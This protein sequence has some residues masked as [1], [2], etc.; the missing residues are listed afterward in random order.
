MVTK[1]RSLSD[2]DEVHALMGIKASLLDPHGALQNWDADSVYPKH[3]YLLFR[4][5]CLGPT[6]I[7]RMVVVL[8]KAK[9]KIPFYLGESS[10][11]IGSLCGRLT[12]PA[13]ITSSEYILP[14]VI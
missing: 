8:V 9:V 7:Y 10:F 5:T 13:T 6:Q 4:I 3:G 1:A 12:P 2:V 14:V 11:V